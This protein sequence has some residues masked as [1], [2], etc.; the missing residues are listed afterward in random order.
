[1]NLPAKTTADL[2]RLQEKVD[3][4]AYSEATIRQYRANWRWWVAWCALRGVT[5]MPPF[6]ADLI[7]EA[8][9][10]R[11]SDGMKRATINALLNTL[12]IASKKA[13]FPSPSRSIELREWLQAKFRQDVAK[14]QHQATGLTF[15]ILQDILS[16]LDQTAPAGARNGA[17]AG[18]AYD[19]LLRSDEIVRAQWADLVT[20]RDGS[21]VLIIR[22]SKT[23]QSGEGKSVYVS[24]ESLVLI[25][26]WR[27]WSVQDGPIF[28]AITGAAPHKSMNTRTVRRIFGSLGG[29]V[30][31]PELS[32][33]SARVGAAQ[34][35]MAASIP[36]S[37]I[38]TAGRWKNPRMPARYG[39]ATEAVALGQA[40][41]DAVRDMAKRKANR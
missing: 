1:M 7:K 37:A 29:M 38:M 9:T 35:A 24:P 23:D 39:E 18:L 15:E 28:H 30:G 2:K 27:R 13:G 33:H 8:V 40:R 20:A 25:H 11:I 3:T 16:R 32:G 22:R 19:A 34:D 31:L 4:S 12:G 14:A 36:L 6:G 41:L 17:M 26:A 10:Q 21:T 5:P